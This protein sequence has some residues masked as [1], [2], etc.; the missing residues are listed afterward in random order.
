MVLRYYLILV[1]DLS[2]LRGSLSS[3]NIP[4]YQTVKSYRRGLIHRV[5][6]ERLPVDRGGKVAKR[7]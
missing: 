5:V 2:I 4:R 6:E 3:A 7:A 1:L